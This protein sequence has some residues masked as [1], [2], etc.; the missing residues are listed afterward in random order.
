MSRIAL[1]GVVAL[2]F[3]LSSL[4]FCLLA[5]G[6]ASANGI[7]YNDTNSI[8]DTVFMLFIVNLPI[9]AVWFAGMTY[10]VILRWGP[11]AG[12]L[13]EG[14]SE[15]MTAVV[16]SSFMIAVLGTLIDLLTFYEWD[17]HESN[18]HF[19]PSQSELL[20][21][22]AAASAVF[23]VFASIYLVSLWIMRLG[24]ME[25]FVPSAAMAAMN[26]VMWM[27]TGGTGII[28]HV[29]ISVIAFFIAIYFL[30]KLAELHKRTFPEV[31][32]AE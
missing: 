14:R 19:W 25:S 29:I 11:K 26:P 9:D 16:V 1:K 32:V 2:A 12:R 24:R 6:H 7:Y 31:P 10:L 30:L 5:S 4:T 20:F 13:R 17:I 27:I 15:F 22:P 3:V 28:L 23:A 21:S 18:V 8:I